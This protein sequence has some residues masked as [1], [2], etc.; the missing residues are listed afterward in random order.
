MRSGGQAD[1]SDGLAVTAEALRARVARLFIA[2]GLPADASERL[3]E[4]LV[5]A[6]LQGVPSHGVMQAEIYL[7][8]LRLG[9]AARHERAACIIDHDA[10]AV[11]DAGHMF[12]HL[13]AEQAMMF[14]VEKA[15]RFGNGTVA[16]RN[17]FHFGIAGRYAEMA[18]GAG[19][20]GIAMCNVRPLMPAPG[21]AE[22]LVGNNPVAIA[23]PTVGEI[24]LVLDMAMSE[25]AFAK[26]RIAAA[27][28]A[29]IPANWAVAGDG[30]PTTDPKTAMAGMLLPAA[31]PK[32]FGLAFMVDLMCGLLAD[33]GWGDD[34]QGLYDNLSQPN[35]CSYLFMAIDVGHFRRRSDFEAETA[36]AAAR[37]RGSRRV[38][39]IDRITVPGERKWQQKHD[40]KGYVTLSKATADALARLE[41]DRSPP[42]D[43]DQGAPTADTTV[44]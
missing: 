39:G 41:A 21:G 16:V 1:D 33:G 35:N 31:G 29:A 4:A 44:R 7:K 13:A 20:I 23:L 11:L 9:S 42:Q 24:P 19:A 27:A 6:D 2:E 26:L 36:R 22:R 8:R 37:V 43:S 34:V 40:S 14:A 17:G 18:A 28:G 30:T 12:G 5:D 25:A 3:A 15:H 32:G 38:P 10:I